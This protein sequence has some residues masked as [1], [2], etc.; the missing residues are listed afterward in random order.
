M[1]DLNK[2]YNLDA[3]A[4]LSLLDA[5]S[6]DC[7]VTSPPYYGQ[8]DY[9]ADGQ[10][11]LEASPEEYRDRLVGVFEG[12]RRVLKPR[13]TLWLNIGDCY[14]GGKGYKD[15]YGRKYMS[16]IRENGKEP[17]YVRIT[18]YK[19]PFIKRKD[20]IGI[21]W[22]LALALRDAG[23][24]LRNDIIW[25]KPNAMPEAVMDRCVS[26]HEHLFLLAK[27]ANYHFDY[28]AILEP[29]ADDRYESRHKRDVWSISTGRSKENHPA[30]FP[31]RLIVDCIKAG[32]PE[33]GIVLDPFM[34]SGTTAIVARQFNRQYV[35]FEIN[36]GYMEIFKSKLT[37][38]LKSLT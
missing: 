7:C 4:G 9:A 28:R 11:G 31:E 8:R 35:G 14:W 6:I 18:G 23:W 26:S 29:G 34:G 21:P 24:Y 25:Q 1:L 22:M 12:V 17:V 19:H 10:I 13:G 5:E 16:E 36:P 20:M 15:G 3:T 38:E 27:S 33:R 2:I 30:T 32:C 37:S